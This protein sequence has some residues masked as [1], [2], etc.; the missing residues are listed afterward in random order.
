MIKLT[1]EYIE[2]NNNKNKYTNFNL[3]IRRAIRENW[4][5]ISKETKST[6]NRRII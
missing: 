6:M 3:V 1:D 5:N 4:F 2:S